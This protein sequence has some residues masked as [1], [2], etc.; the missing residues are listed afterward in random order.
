MQEVDDVVA[1]V[2]Q[3]CVLEG[4]CLTWMHLMPRVQHI[5]TDPPYDEEFHNVAR[6]VGAPDGAK[7]RDEYGFAGLTYLQRRA[8]GRCF[9]EI[10]QRWVLVFSDPESSCYWRE[11]LE[12]PGM[13]YCRKGIWIK[14]G[15]M[16]QISGD[17]PASGHEEITIAHASVDVTPGRPRWN[18]GGARGV[19]AYPVVSAVNDGREHPTP[20]PLALMLDLVNAFTDPGDVILDPF[21]GS[22]ATGVAALVSGRRFIGIEVKAQWAQLSR[23]RLLATETDSTLQAQRRGQMPLFAGRAK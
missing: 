4:D 18:G 5:I 19:W 13:R 12:Y 6:V 1:G 9:A 16:P 7:R 8:L 2:R 22:G 21:C 3:W 11:A 10:A 15:C 23:E 14:L 20:K 17:R